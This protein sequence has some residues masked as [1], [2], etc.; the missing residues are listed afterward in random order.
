MG[1]PVQKILI[2]EWQLQRVWGIRQREGPRNM[3]FSHALGEFYCRGS[4][5]PVFFCL[6]LFCFLGP[7]PWHMGVPRLG[8]ESEQHLLAPAT[9][10]PDVSR[11]CNLHHSSHQ[12][13]ILNPLSKTRDRTRVLWILV[14][15]ITRW[16]TTGIS[17]VLAM[18][19]ACRSSW[20]GIKSAPQQWQ[21][22]L[23]NPLSHEG[24][25]RAPPLRK[26]GHESLDTVDLLFSLVS[27]YWRASLCF[28]N[29]QGMALPSFVLLKSS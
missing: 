11:V 14:G 4:W 29:V 8:V 28:S 16:T 24:T 23:L 26:A 20:E 3:K 10:T 7:H 2:P 19:V 6:F 9:A 13:Q 17:F 22:Q 18:S 12:C 1:K 27:C 15:F 25:P 5:T 21:C